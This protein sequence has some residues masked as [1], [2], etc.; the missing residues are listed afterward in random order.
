[1][2][3]ELS[4]NEQLFNAVTALTIANDQYLVRKAQADSARHEEAQ[5]FRNVNLAQSHFDALVAQ[6]KKSAPRETSWRRSP[7]EAAS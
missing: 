2:V 7:G 5:A 6:V 3:K 4:L 1:M